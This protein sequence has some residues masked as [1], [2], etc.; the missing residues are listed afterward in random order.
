[1]DFSVLS[2]GRIVI[3]WGRRVIREKSSFGTASVAFHGPADVDS[4]LW[5]RP[6]RACRVQRANARLCHT[7]GGGGGAT[8][9]RP[10]EVESDGVFFVGRARPF[11]DQSETASFFFPHGPRRKW[12]RILLFFSFFFPCP[13]HLHFSGWILFKKKKNFPVSNMN[14]T[15]SKLSMG[16][17]NLY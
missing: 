1:M 15:P 3:R 6:V 16:F 13:L 10:T 12:N 17:Q 14:A 4:T 5:P 9:L 2:E 8:L 11:D 7:D